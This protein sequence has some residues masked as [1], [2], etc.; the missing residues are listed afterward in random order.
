MSLFNERKECAYC[1]KTGEKTDPQ[2]GLQM[3]REYDGHTL[4]SSHH[5]EAKYPEHYTETPAIQE[6]L[7]ND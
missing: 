5:S 7:D 6:W 4:C 2:T 3:F 1:G